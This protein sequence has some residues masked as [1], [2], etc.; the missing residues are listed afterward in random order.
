[1]TAVAAGKAEYETLKSE[2]AEVGLEVPQPS[3]NDGGC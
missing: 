2:F 1:M 3:K